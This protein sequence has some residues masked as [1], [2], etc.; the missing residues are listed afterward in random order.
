MA[1]LDRQSG[2][3]GR[4]RSDWEELI[5]KFERS[6]LSRQRFCME[7]SIPVSSFDYWRRKLRRERSPAAS[8]FIE[9][10]KVSSLGSDWDV[11]LE[12]GGGVVL[13]LRRG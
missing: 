10:P 3:S 5:E 13:R 1:R 6:G 7:G 11:E 9:L 4:T 8:S 2:A 12:L